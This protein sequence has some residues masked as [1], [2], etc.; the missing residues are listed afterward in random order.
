M[1]PWRLMSN[2]C[3][4]RIPNRI[5]PSQ[6]IHSFHSGASQVVVSKLNTSILQH[7]AETLALLFTSDIASIAGMYG[8]VT[9]SGQIICT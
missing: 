9:L 4:L 6:R 3:V 8:L 2:T 5:F 7:P 1:L